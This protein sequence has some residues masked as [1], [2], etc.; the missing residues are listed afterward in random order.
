ML[1][2][3]N[4]FCGEGGRFSCPIADWF[5]I[6]G[7]WSGELSMLTWASVVT[8][9][10]AKLEKEENIQIWGAFYP[11]GESKDKQSKLRARAEE[12]YKEATPE[13]YK[14]KGL[15]Y[16]RDTFDQLGY[17]DDAMIVNDELYEKVLKKHEGKYEVYDTEF[18][19]LHY[20][21]LEED[22]V[23]REFIGSKWVV[24]VDYHS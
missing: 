5:V 23:S 2:N 12:L 7:R 13:I 16:D 3:D 15:V 18:D 20:F 1:I 17:Q 11:E 8:D 24:V 21:D 14:G 22:S 6:G 9:K 4:S 19:M 10:I